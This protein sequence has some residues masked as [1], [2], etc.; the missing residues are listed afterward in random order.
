[1]YH[2]NHHV[3]LFTVHTS[4]QT[5]P[6]L[7]Y[8][9]FL[10]HLKALVVT[11]RCKD[12]LVRNRKQLCAMCSSVTITHHNIYTFTQTSSV[13]CS[14]QRSP[15][16]ITC[17]HLTL[18]Q[19][20]SFFT[21]MNL[22]FKRPL[23]VSQ[24]TPGSVSLFPVTFPGSLAPVWLQSW[25]IFTCFNSEKSPFRLQ[26]SRECSVYSSCY[27]ATCYN[28]VW[29]SIAVHC[30]TLQL[31]RMCEEEQTGWVCDAYTLP[32]VYHVKFPAQKGNSLYFSAI[33][34]SV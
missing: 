12:S 19:H 30:W 11:F 5:V 6:L 29:A 27:S 16:H 9:L 18:S 10:D 28:R 15:K 7:E 32:R 21:S 34:N 33:I 2:E 4:A 17:P 26:S 8:T 20:P 1:M 25:I 3:G 31:A 23:L 14:L 22:P 24:M 13:T